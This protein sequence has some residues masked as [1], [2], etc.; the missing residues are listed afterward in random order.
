[1]IDKGTNQPPALFHKQQPD[2]Q[3]QRTV[4][5][6]VN[7]TMFACPS[8]A[9][10]PPTSAAGPFRGGASDAEPDATPSRAKDRASRSP[11]S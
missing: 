9:R 6:H 8:T 5:C 11:R 10:E 1:M 7:R 2:Q 3:H 4:T